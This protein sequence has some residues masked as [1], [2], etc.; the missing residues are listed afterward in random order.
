[1]RSTNLAS[2]SS[3][4][5]QVWLPRSLRLEITSPD[6]ENE[7]Q[8][9]WSEREFFV[10]YRSLWQHLIWTFCFLMTAFQCTLQCINCVLLM[11][12]PNC[13]FTDPWQD[14]QN[15][16]NHWPHWP[17]LYFSTH[18][19]CKRSYWQVLATKFIIVVNVIQS[20][21]RVLFFIEYRSI[22]SG[23]SYT[24]WAMIDFHQWSL[25]VSSSTEK[26]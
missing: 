2:S 1:M 17:S 8:R 25:Q 18:V 11:P 26:K 4:N 14:L 22:F 13:L 23:L 12:L 24:V 16:M 5:T 15:D 7:W 3:V 20:F 10:G 6:S 9:T 19:H 21:T